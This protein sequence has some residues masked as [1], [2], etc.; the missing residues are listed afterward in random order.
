MIF[1]FNKIQYLQAILATR[2]HRQIHIL[3]LRT[4]LR[5]GSQCAAVVL[6][7]SRCVDVVVIR[8]SDCMMRWEIPYLTVI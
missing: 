8:I 6:S 7:P 2:M 5:A 3:P 1:M 4:T